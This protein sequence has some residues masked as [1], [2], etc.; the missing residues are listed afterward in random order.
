MIG[1]ILKE[2][3]NKKGLTINKSAE[4]FGIAPRTY[5]SYESEEREPNILM[6]NK[7]ADYYNVT[8]DYLL[9]RAEKNDPLSMLNISAGEKDAMAKY[10][11]LP[12]STRQI[13]IDVMIQLAE[14]AKGKEKPPVFIFRRFATSKA[15]AGAGYNLDNEDDWQEL[16]VIDTPEARAAD[17]AVEV[18]GRSMEPTFNDGDIVYVVMSPDVPVGKVGLFRQNGNGY[19]KEAGEDFLR[20]VNRDFPDIYP[21]DGEIDVIGMVIGKAKL[22]E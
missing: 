16:E 11:L 1:N 7:I 22:P 2:L 14:A 13:I 6:L 19:I 4:I 3:R 21:K 10:V 18:D 12:E 17:F 9:G 8:V 15:S 5:S 20:S